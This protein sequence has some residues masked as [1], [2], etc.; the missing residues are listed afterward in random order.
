V[1]IG[2]AVWKIEAWKAL[3]IEPSSLANEKLLE[4]ILE[5]D[6]ACWASRRNS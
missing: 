2:V 6:I 1:P 3:A 5:A 4:D